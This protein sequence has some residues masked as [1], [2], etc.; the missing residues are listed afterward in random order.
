[1]YDLS[2]NPFGTG[3]GFKFN[4]L[5]ATLGI[6]GFLLEIDMKDFNVN[7]L[8][9]EGHVLT[10]D[11]V[12]YLRGLMLS[13]S[14]KVNSHNISNDHNINSHHPLVQRITPKPFIESLFRC[15]AQT[16]MS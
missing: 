10:S 1:M 3:K 14:D 13:T 2:I 15:D 7:D 12:A 16:P 6:A 4:A 8:L 5:T 11:E 9:K